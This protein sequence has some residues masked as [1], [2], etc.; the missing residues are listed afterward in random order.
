MILP[1][2]LSLSILLIRH[3]LGY[4]LEE[5]PQPSQQVTRRLAQRTAAQ[6]VQTYLGKVRR[7]SVLRGKA[8]QIAH[9][10]ANRICRQLRRSGLQSEGRRAPL[11]ARQAQQKSELGLV[12]ALE[13][14]RLGLK[15]ENPGRPPEVRL[16]YLPN[17]HTTRHAERVEHDVDGRAVRQERHVFLG[18]D[19]GDDSLVSVSTGHLVANR[20]LPLLCQVHL[21]QLNHAGRQLVGL[22]DLVD[23]ILGLFL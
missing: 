19:A 6:A 10:I 8:L 4:A 1:L 21:D 12:R 18:H 15:P 16:E 7:A 9:Q 20:D 17:V 23:L 13:D 2:C 14:R 5:I 3:F 11:E 22:Q